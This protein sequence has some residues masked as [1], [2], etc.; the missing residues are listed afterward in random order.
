MS[1]VA[2]KTNRPI[3]Q[4]LKLTDDYVSFCLDEASVYVIGLWEA[5]KIV[6]KTKGSNMNGNDFLKTLAKSKDI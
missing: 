5:G 6:N 2:H 1:I 3:S 4:L